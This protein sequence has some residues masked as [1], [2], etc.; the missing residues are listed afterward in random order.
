MPRALHKASL[1]ESIVAD[2]R[3][4]TYVLPQAGQ[5]PPPAQVGG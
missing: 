5:T 4:E 2:F 3:I 1:K